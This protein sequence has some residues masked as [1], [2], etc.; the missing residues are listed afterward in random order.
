MK[1]TLSHVW[2]KHGGKYDLYIKADNDTYVI[3][4]NLRAFLLNED[5]NTHDYH[6]FRV[7][8]S[9]KVDHHTYN[10]G[11]AGYVMRSVKELVEK[12]FGDS[13]YCR[14]ADK[15]FDDLEVRLCLES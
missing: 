3:M 15:A 13:K 6:G 5:L 8:A 14:Q 1:N 12:G 9:G 7:A 4:E 11:G 2:R 10:S